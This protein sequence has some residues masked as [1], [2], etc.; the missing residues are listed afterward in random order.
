M[1]PRSNLSVDKSSS[2]TVIGVYTGTSVTSH[3]RSRNLRAKALSL[4]QD[5]HIISAAPAVI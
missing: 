1:P 3:F 2:S 4:K 5:P